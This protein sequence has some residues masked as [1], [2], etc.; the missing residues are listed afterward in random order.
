MIGDSDTVTMFNEKS[1]ILDS[2]DNDNTEPEELPLNPTK[3]IPE[4]CGKYPKENVTDEVI[5]TDQDENRSHNETSIDNN[6]NENDGQGSENNIQDDVIEISEHGNENLP[7]RHVEID[8]EK[9]GTIFVY[10]VIFKYI[11]WI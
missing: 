7:L 8:E 4:N 5:V 10:V 1:K 2:K 9:Q 3:L 11:L 6:K